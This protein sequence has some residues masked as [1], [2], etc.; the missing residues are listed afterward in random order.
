L[1]TTERYVTLAKGLDG[2]GA[3]VVAGVLFG[4]T[5]RKAKRSA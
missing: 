3:S 5:K 4:E 2:A 1:E